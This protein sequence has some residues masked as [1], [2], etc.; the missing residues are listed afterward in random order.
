MQLKETK[1]IK[2]VIIK[3]LNEK[4]REFEKIQAEIV[5]MKKEL[6]KGNNQSRFEDSSKIL[7]DILNNQIPSSNNSGLGYDQ[8][9]LYKGSNTTK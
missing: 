8:K 2:E 5:H 6:E 7:N 9:K 4:Q 3:Q 1:I